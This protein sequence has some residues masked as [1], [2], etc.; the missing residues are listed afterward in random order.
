MITKDLHMHTAYCDGKNTPEEMVQSAI[1]KG[2]K[3]VGVSSHSYTF[4]DTSYCMQKEAVPRYLAELRYLR[5]KYFDQ[6]H[7][8]CGVEQDYYSDYPTEDFDYVIGSVHYIKVDDA[9]IPIDE[10]P[11]VLRL[12]VD[13][14]FRGDVYALVDL[15][16]KIV[17]DVVNK[18][19]CDIIGHFD[20]ISKFIEKEPLFDVGDPRYVNAWKAAVD[21]LLKYDVPFEINT[22]AMSRGYKTQPY[23]STEMI[24]YIRE[25]GGRFVLSSDAHC[26]ENVAYD[27][28]RF[29]E[30]AESSI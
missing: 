4:F 14:Y 21:E 15:Y 13:K 17:A 16:F 23:P 28:E 25:K 2:L 1:K 22:G 9:Y 30:S 7:I 3:T 29:I 26:A 5:T 20:L 18:T 10:N 12:A 27:F 24:A 8:L 11:A 6:I 19:G